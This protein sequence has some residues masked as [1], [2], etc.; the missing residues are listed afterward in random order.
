[1]GKAETNSI[2]SRQTEF[3]FGAAV[4][5]QNVDGI[6]HNES[7]TGRGDHGSNDAD[8]TNKNGPQAKCNEYREEVGDQANQT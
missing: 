1:M 7:H 8:F 5:T 6:V 2:M 3:I 4:F